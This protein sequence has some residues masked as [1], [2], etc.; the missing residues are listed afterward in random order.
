MQ[1]LPRG[2]DSDP[3][4]YLCRESAGRR[5]KQQLSSLY[6]VV[7]LFPTPVLLPHT[8]CPR[9]LGASI[10][11]IIL[12]TK[13]SPSNILPHPQSVFYGAAA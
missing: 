9:P 7:G 4:R 12:S 3:S 11:L 6:S 2:G 10:F 8:A 13:G 5:T 1:G